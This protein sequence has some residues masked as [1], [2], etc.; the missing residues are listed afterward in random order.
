MSMNL[1][2]VTEIFKNGLQEL[3]AMAK[4]AEH[5]VIN[6]EAATLLVAN[7]VNFFTKSFLISAC[8]HL[9]MCIKEIV[10]KLAEDIDVRL[11]I[12]SIPSSFIKWRLN[13]KLKVDFSGAENL[14]IG[15]TNK[16]IDDLVSG[17]VYKTKEAMAIV[18]VD[19]EINKSEWEHWKELIQN[20]VTRRNKIVHHNDDASDLS[21]GDVR[22]HIQSV[23]AYIEFIESS[24]A[25]R[26][27]RQ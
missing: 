26:P 21:L 17:N 27:A 8:A 10:S 14:I 7:N 2:Q 5:E 16:E 22:A 12:A 1:Q 25:N 24:C 11:S 20:I 9:E 6:S 13:P 19:L 23:I 3:D 18:G 4:A 15:M